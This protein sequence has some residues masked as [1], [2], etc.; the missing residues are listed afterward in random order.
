MIV[1]GIEDMNC[2]VKVYEGTGEDMDV[3][4]LEESR[5]S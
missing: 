4:E 2:V 3:G 5:E 1:W